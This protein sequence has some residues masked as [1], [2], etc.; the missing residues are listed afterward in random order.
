MNVRKGRD[1][2]WHL[3]ITGLLYLLGHSCFWCQPT[4]CVC[5]PTGRLWRPPE[6]PEPWWLLGRPRRGELRIWSRL[7][8]PPE[9]DRLY[10]SQLLHRLDQQR[11]R[12]NHLRGFLTSINNV[13]VITE[14]SVVPCRWWPSTEES[15]I[16]NNNCDLECVASFSYCQVEE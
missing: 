9:A 8:R 16:N 2:T 13:C 15:A 10:T 4:V 11:E 5:W 7:Q 14:L 12:P 3:Q 6:L 1:W